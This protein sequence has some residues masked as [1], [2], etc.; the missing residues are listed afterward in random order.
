MVEVRV[1]FFARSRELS[2]TSEALLKLEAGGTTKTLMQRLLDEVRVT[3]GWW[4]C[5]MCDGK[6]IP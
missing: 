4:R 3:G 5:R 2:G 6:G 1:L